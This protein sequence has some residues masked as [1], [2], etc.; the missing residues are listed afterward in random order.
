MADL[1]FPGSGNF[2]SGDWSN[3]TDG[4]IAN[5]L[6][7]VASTVLPPARAAGPAHTVIRGARAAAEAEAAAAATRAA[8]SIGPVR[9]NRVIAGGRLLTFPEANRLILYDKAA[10]MLHQLDARNRLLGIAN[11]PA[12]LPSLEH[13]DT[14]NGQITAIRQQQRL[15]EIEGHHQFV[16]QFA[17]WFKLNGIEPEDYVTY[18]WAKDHRLSGGIHSGPYPWNR[19][20][21]N[22]INENRQTSPD[23]IH[24]QLFRMLRP[25]EKP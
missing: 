20:W 14:F 17:D 2:V 15:R 21:G 3:I 18:M 11:P 12:W 4:D 5:L 10:D 22:F 19:Q 6:F 16:R 7:S 24:R 25:W 8:A 1:L 13:V 23:E 9:G